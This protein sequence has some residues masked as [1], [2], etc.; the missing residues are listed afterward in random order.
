MK[1][2]KKQ[3]VEP[4]N[5]EPRAEELPKDYELVGICFECRLG[6]IARQPGGRDPLHS[7]GSSYC[8]VKS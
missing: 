2:P 7:N 1:K 6:L 4:V 3:K 8:G 5:E